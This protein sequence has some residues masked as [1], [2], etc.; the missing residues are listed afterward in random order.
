MHAIA[1]EKSLACSD[2]IPG[3]CLVKCHLAWARIRQHY[4]QLHGVMLRF[5][6][7]EQLSE[8][9]EKVSYFLLSKSDLDLLYLCTSCPDMLMSKKSMHN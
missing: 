4:L 1:L 6:R 9:Q 7:G 8:K 3:H 2:L 5:S